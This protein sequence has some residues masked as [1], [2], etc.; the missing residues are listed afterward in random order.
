MGHSEYDPVAKERRP[1][2]AGPK[3]LGAKRALKAQQT[4]AIRF[5]LD[6]ERRMRHWGLHT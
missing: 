3:T 6:R 5:W 2:N 1:C 4:W